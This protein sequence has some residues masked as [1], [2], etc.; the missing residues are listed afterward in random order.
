MAGPFDFSLYPQAPQPQNPLSTMGSVVGLVG[1]MNQNKMFQQEFAA[2]QAMGPIYQQSIEV[3]P[4]TGQAELNYG[5]ALQAMAGD[6]AIAWK[7][8]EFLAQAQAREAQQIA[9]QKLQVETAIA[10]NNEILKGVV[11][12]RAKP[13]GATKN[14]VFQFMKSLVDQKRVSPD[15]L[16]PYVQEIQALPDNDPRALDDYLHVKTLQGQDANAQGQYFLGQIAQINMPQGT[17]VGRQ[18]PAFGFQGQTFIPAGVSPE[19]AAGIAQR[20]TAPVTRTIRD[21]QTG[22]LKEVTSTVGQLSGTDQM[23]AGGPAAP[24]GAPQVPG[25]AVA[26]PTGSDTDALRGTTSV[27]VGAVEGTKVVS[28]GAGKALLGAYDNAASSPTRLFNLREAYDAIDATQT[29]PGT[30]FTN[31]VKSYFNSLSPDWLESIGIKPEWDAD[32]VKNYDKAVKYT[33]QIAA[34]TGSRS[35][36][37]LASAITGNPSTRINQLAAKDVLKAMMALERM[38]QAELEAFQQSGKSE[39]EYNKWKTSEW[40]KNLDPRV[41]IVEYLSEPEKAKLKQSLLDK[42]AE[43]KRFEDSWVR[44]QGY[45]VLP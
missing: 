41:F 15:K 34:A 3:N 38:G 4:L 42:P 22:R 26:A 10:M 24:Q 36:A 19:A 1:Q 27:P 23:L 29:G 28:E 17:F 31:A 11:G 39:A 30:Q 5:K 33:S 16:L 2:R 32:D 6:P 14:D 18:S 45:G 35:D 7:A 37:A 44:M 43:R 20:G 40:N 13:G 25:S 8:Q 21:P 12:I 9:N